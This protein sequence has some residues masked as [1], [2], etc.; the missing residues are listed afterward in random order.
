MMNGND[1]P[2]TMDMEQ[3][4]EILPYGTRKRDMLTGETVTIG[5]QMTFPPRA[6]YILENSDEGE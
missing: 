6:L 3:T 5:E 2:V 1:K 4:L